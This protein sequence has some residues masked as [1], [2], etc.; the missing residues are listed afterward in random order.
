LTTSGIRGQEACKIRK[1]DF[2]SGYSRLMIKLPGI[3]TKNK[4][5][6]RVII[7]IEVEEYVKKLLSKLKDDDLVF[8]TNNNSLKDR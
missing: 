5:P 2:V 8:G 4:K 3:D 7:G 6:R 1:R